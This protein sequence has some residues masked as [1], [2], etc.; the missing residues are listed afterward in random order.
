MLSDSHYGF[1]SGTKKSLLGLDYPLTFRHVRQD[2][3]WK[4]TFLL[5]ISREFSIHQE[6]S[7]LANSQLHYKL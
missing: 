1:N 5:G 4:L 3:A 2:T 7:L 6:A